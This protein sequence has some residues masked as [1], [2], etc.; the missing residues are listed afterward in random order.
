MQ[1]DHT[2]MLYLRKRGM[3]YLLYQRTL[4]GAQSNH[5]VVESG[6]FVLEARRERIEAHVYTRLGHFSW[7]KERLKKHSSS[8]EE[9]SGT[10]SKDETMKSSDSGKQYRELLMTPEVQSRYND[11]VSSSRGRTRSVRLST[12]L[13][14]EVP[15]SEWCVERIWEHRGWGFIAGEPKTYKSTF[16]C[17]LAV[18]LAT[19]TPF[20]GHFNVS[21]PGP[22]LIV[23]EENT[24][25][26][27]WARLN[28]ILRGRDLGGK[29]HGLSREG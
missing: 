28:R 22:V 3:M 10:S 13:G 23:Q 25:N 12:L 21:K 5:L 11:V 27:Q 17:D 24:E 4:P 9:V 7:S 14:R 19:G 2:S 18:S 16:T 26:I 29:F 6:Y 1:S 15:Q 8:Y 20:L